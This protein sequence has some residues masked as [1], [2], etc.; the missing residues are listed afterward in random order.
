M[1][2]MKKTAK[3]TATM[4]KCKSCGKKME[5]SKCKSCDKKY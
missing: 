5:G 1:S 3:K 4:K 2:P